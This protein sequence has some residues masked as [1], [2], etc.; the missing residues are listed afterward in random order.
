[1]PGEEDDDD[2]AI[3]FLSIMVNVLLQTKRERGEEEKKDE[4]SKR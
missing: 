3:G 2:D 4:Q 1:V